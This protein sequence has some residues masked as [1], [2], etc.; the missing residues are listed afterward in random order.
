MKKSL[1]KI[2]S[3]NNKNFLDDFDN[4][5]FGGYLGAQDV[6]KIDFSLRKQD[7]LVTLRVS[8]ELLALLKKAATKHKTK[9]Q[10]LMRL[11]LEKNIA[12][13]V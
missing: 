3:P 13:Y 8:S 5:D 2:L 6:Q 9:Y 10:K 1:K 7:K 11:V 4:T 12:G